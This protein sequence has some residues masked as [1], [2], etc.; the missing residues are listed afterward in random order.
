MSAN[1]MAPGAQQKRLAAYLDRLAQA[2]GHTDREKPLK[3]YCTG[4][5]LPGERK[6]VEPM[7]ARLAP[8]NVR[9]THQ[10]LHHVVAD[11][12]WSDEAVLRQVRKY[13]LAAMM[14][15]EAVAAW[16]VDDT[17]FVKKGTHSVGVARQYC[18]QVGKQE[19]CRVAVSL[20]VATQTTSLPVEWRLYL[21]ESWAQDAKRREQAGVP[22]EIS[23][24]TKPA[25][26]LQQIRGA[27]EEEIPTAPVL[28]DAGYGNDTQFRE[29]VTGLNLLYVLG[30]SSSTTVWKMGEGPLPKK[31]W[32]GRGQPPKRLRRDA[33][34]RPVS[35]LALA[36]G[37]PERAWKSVTWRPGTKG[38]LRSQF[39]A[40][41]VRPAHRD[42]KRTEPRPEEWLLIE[43]PK[44][45]AEP[46]KYWLSTLPV[47]TK[48]PDL[49][50]LAKL[51]WIIERDYE[52]LKQELGLGHFEGRGWR[53]FHHHATLCIAAYGFLVAER[54]RFSP[55]A[56][57]GQLGISLPQIPAHF[58]PRG[59]ARPQRTAPSVVNRN[60]AHDDRA[61]SAATA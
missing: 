25:I 27:V 22:E 57:S 37:L 42:E 45:E 54:S 50:R 6:S 40:V 13:A 10:S 47:E 53:G 28:G 16:V 4:L 26:A 30:V 20:S 19:N 41:R 15:K 3:A 34:H 36:Q 1:F 59:A 29:G 18:G 48:I 8:D 14:E 32:S 61:N 49:V 9:R 51:R 33:R 55:S 56:R 21:P 35:V 2:A 38:W 23:F 7:A 60:A 39:A 12:P 11:A 44:G 46:T 58:R 5:L 17:G 52:E 43:W 24:A 31:A